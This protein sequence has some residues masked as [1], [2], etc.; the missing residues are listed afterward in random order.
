MN[1][2]KF[3]IANNSDGS[4]CLSQKGETITYC[5]TTFYTIWKNQISKTQQVSVTE[6]GKY[7]RYSQTSYF[8]KY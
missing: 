1:N 7:K 5:N 8:I 3:L 6:I 4:N 2:I